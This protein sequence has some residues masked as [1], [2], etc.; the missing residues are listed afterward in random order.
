MKEPNQVMNMMKND[1]PI[2]MTYGE[3]ETVQN[4]NNEEMDDDETEDLNE[5]NETE[6]T[7]HR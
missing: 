4:N 2:M 6:M 5:M 7:A 1:V 3:D